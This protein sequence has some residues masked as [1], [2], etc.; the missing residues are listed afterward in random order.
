MG[1]GNINHVYTNHLNENACNL[2]Q[3]MKYSNDYYDDPI[4]DRS[5]YSVQS[6]I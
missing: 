2:E 1:T 5:Y 4:N 6:S 3:L